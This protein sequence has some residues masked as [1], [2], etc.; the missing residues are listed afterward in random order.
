M[1]HCYLMSP[2]PIEIRMTFSN[3]ESP[4]PTQCTLEVV[5]CH[6]H[7]AFRPRQMQ[8]YRMLKFMANA[9]QRLETMLHQM[10]QCELALT[11]TMLRLAASIASEVAR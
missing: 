3:I 4:E 6:F 7:L 5:Q 8:Q 1:E 11:P 10:V 9:Q 2:L